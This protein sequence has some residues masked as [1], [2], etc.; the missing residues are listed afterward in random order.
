M[1]EITI[2]IK[3]LSA[4]NILGFLSEFKEDMQAQQFGAMLLE[5]VLD[6]EEG[7]I[8]AITDDQFEEVQKEVQI[9]ILMGRAPD[10][11][12]SGSIFKSRGGE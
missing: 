6:F 8:D 11:A 1:A 12:K 3:A 10:N 2:K 9:A 5:S 4:I 7:C